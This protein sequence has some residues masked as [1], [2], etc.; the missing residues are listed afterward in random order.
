MR[1]F[2]PQGRKGVR[3]NR[4]PYDLRCD[5]Y[6]P[7]IIEQGME[8][9]RVN[10]EKPMPDEDERVFYEVSLSKGDSFLVTGN[11]KHYPASARVVTPALFLEIISSKL[12]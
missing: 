5:R 8:A 6:Q 2:V 1:R 10:F 9:S 11:Q 7:H 3:S 12:Q 4:L